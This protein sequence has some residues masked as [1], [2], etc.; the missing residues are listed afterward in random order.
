MKGK[1]PLQL[2]KSTDFFNFIAMNIKQILETDN[3]SKIVGLLT[4]APEGKGSDTIET[5]IKQYDG[6]HD[7]LN[8]P[9]KTVGTGAKQKTVIT[10]KQVIKL[11][12]KITNTALSFL[13]GEPVIITNISE[14]KNATDKAFGEIVRHWD[15]MK[16]HSHNRELCRRLFIE[17]HVAELF[18][19]KKNLDG[20]IEIK[21]YLLCKDNGD[22]IFPHFD[23]YG[24]MDSFTRK[25]DVEDEKGKTQQYIDV[26]M[27]DRM[28]RFHRISGGY[29]RKDFVNG[30]EI[31]DPEDPENEEKKNTII[32]GKIPV[33]YYQQE[34]TEWGDVQSQID[35]F[36]MRLSKFIDTNDY[37]GSPAIK[38]MGELV[39]A[40][41]KG[42][43]GK[44]FTLKG[45]NI[46]GKY[47]YGDIQYLT[48][49]HMP[50]AV[51]LELKE[52]RN[53]IYSLS[54]T[55][56]LS[57][58]NVK[59]SQ[60]LSGIAMKFMFLDAILKAKNHEEVF[61]ENFTRRMNILKQMIA[62]IVNISMADQLKNLKFGFEFQNPLPENVQE[63]VD[64]LVSATGNE[65]IMSRDTAV[66][67]NPLITDAKDELKKMASD[68]E[69]SQL[70]IGSQTFGEPGMQE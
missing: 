23:E 29:E 16:L 60:A 70:E 13:F 31:P 65:R 68:D 22:E 19:L 5:N 7:I 26:Y 69:R 40:P 36:E 52:L 14:D 39:D 38:V 30:V 18:Y 47:S 15:R 43:I 3:S 37:F 46:D 61:S 44:V 24:D 54:S 6:T 11:Q 41:E 63:I 49:E 53:I 66:S 27:A 33:I 12:K 17:T 25:Y 2:K 20:E 28:I 45:Q 50:T 62:K 58:D 21:V 57:F 64:M 32:L 42:E 4:K 51:E 55:P 10:A 59:G 8:R 48:W 35:Q 67:L 34:A 1:R 9:N 56:D